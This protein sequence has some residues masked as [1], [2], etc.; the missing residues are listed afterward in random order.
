MDLR[1]YF[2]L[3]YLKL[4]QNFYIKEHE[5]KNYKITHIIDAT[6]QKT[7][8]N[9]SNQL[10]ISYFPIAI[11]DNNE[12]NIVP[13]FYNIF[14]FID[15]C[16]KSNGRILIHCRAGISRSASFIIAY[17][18]HSKTYSTL[19]ESLL[20]VIR[21]RPIIRPNDSFQEQLIAYEFALNNTNSINNCFEFTEIINENNMLWSQASILSENPFDDIPINSMKS[22]K[23]ELSELPLDMNSS[24]IENPPIAQP[25]KPYL[26]AGSR[27]K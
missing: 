8:L 25:K 19:K 22:D 14:Q 6:N 11:E 5:L 4:F 16:L 13:Y 1:H 24:N 9:I 15:T 20:H 23:I 18:L 10:N 3:S 17:L 7:T 2:Q 21:Q 27:K 26:K 12:A